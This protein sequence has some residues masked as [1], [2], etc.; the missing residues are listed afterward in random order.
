[1][2]YLLVLGGVL[3]LYRR[4]VAGWVLAGGD[5]QTYFFPYWTAAARA[6][7][8]GR[9]PLWNPYLFAGAPLL[10]NSQAGVFYPLNWPL[11]LLAGPSPEGMTRA[12]HWSVLLH[13]CLAVV[14][15]VILARRL[16]LT[17]W[18][19]ALSGL[20]Y[21]GSGYLG[22]HVEHL[23]Q[24]QGLAWLPLLFMVDGRRQTVDGGGRAGERES[25]REGER[26]RGR[27]G[28]WKKQPLPLPSPL[29]IVALAMILLAGHTQ[30]AFIA[31]VGLAVWIASGEWRVANGEWRMA[32]GEWRMASNKF[33]LLLPRLPSPVYRLLSTVYR[34]L[35]PISRLPS[36]V[37]RLPS[38][39]SR[40]PSTVYRLLP[41][42]LAGLI[43]AAQLLPTIELARF[44]PRSGGL[45]W[46]E[47]VSFS[48]RPWE[49][50]R[51][52]L[53]PYLWPPLLPEAVAYIGLVGMLLAAWGGWRALRHR[54]RYG[55]ALL[56][57]GGVGVF[58]AMGGYN[59]LYLA[60][61][62]LGAP[63]F[64]HFRAPA[65]F[66]ALYVL[67]TTLLAGM[68]F[69]S[70][71]ATRHRRKSDGRPRPFYALGMKVAPLLLSGLIYVELLLSA[72]QMPHADA[73]TP[74]AYT[75]LRPAT[76]HLVAAARAADE[77]GQPAG[78][79]LSLSPT[80]FEAGDEVDSE[81]LYGAVLSPD[82]LW[83]YEVAVKQRE[84]LVPNLPLAF[85]VP[86]VDGYD[87]GLLP[88]HHYVNFSRL[89]LAE[90]TLDG[91]LRENLSR[92]PAD[93][94]L[95]LLGVRYVMTDKTGDMWMAD[96]FYDRQFRPHLADGETLT[97]AW[98]PSDFTATALGWLYSGAGEMTAT[99]TSG[100]TVT[101]PLPPR[102][103][104]EG[105]YQAPLGM[106]TELT[107]L[108]VRASTGGLTLTG[109]SLIDGRTGAF[110]PLVLSAA[111]R[112]IHSGD[113][114]IYENLRVLP[115][116][117]LVDEV[118]CAATDDEALALLT[119]PGF[120][121]ARQAVI[122]ACDRLP[123]ASTWP[124]RPAM[125]GSVTVEHYAADTVVIDCSVSSPALLVLSD[126]WYP[127]WRVEVRSL[128]DHSAPVVRQDIWRTDILFR[129]ILIEPGAWRVTLT[130][131]PPL[132][133]LGIGVSLVGMI[134][135]GLYWRY[136]RAL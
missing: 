43:A 29:S 3:W 94:W 15:V 119:D 4:L 41:F 46:R 38:P 128:A 51:A 116:A 80:L 39:I 111:F 73:T 107:T 134:I 55:C 31:L 36:P 108:T 11:W 9:L 54:D 49:L 121:P 67:A 95:S 112:L 19:A 88:L 30:M 75:D 118:R 66:F 52:L 21:A 32:N 74:R 81:A 45:P 37:Y 76:A 77:A 50:P 90:G 10:A 101:L 18:S 131:R 114:K 127:G 5:L 20:L 48:V 56:L 125:A 68:G 82:A 106:A 13:L 89:F 58:L 84:V 16:G 93:R 69:D 57:L 63:G 98:L 133:P 105:V 85:Q 61:A 71:L 72:E 109:A 96:V 120:D 24:L 113:V 35:S 14:N 64:A 59:P 62:R 2:D 70:L 130:Y 40:L 12:L 27:A 123:L 124:A 7:Q 87:G 53:P 86:A 115:R 102:P 23:N 47:A 22:L 129:G 100:E 110:Y 97:L 117:F 135:L 92:I 132:I 6:L 136:R 79:F 103:A 122:A 44:S 78:R 91:R 1:M 34:L 25:G 42:T 8:A 60:A 104:D 65:R 83:A 17:R 33:P 26:E 99:S 126:A 28:E